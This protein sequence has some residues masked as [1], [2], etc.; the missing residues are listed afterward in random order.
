[1]TKNR[2]IGIRN[3]LPWSIKAD[4]ARFKELTLGWPCIMGRNTWASLP[5][6]P[7]PGRPN[8][9]ISSS[10]A[11]CDAPG[12]HVLPSL[13][14]AISYCKNSGYKKMFI[15]G[16]ASIYCEALSIA[17]R[18]ELTLIGRDYEGDVFFPEI[19]SSIWKIIKQEDFDG[20]SFLSYTK[21]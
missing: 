13:E 11:N 7:L 12:A 19:N 2:A 3:S 14:K 18:I 1:M 9:V 21:V 20:F 15:C 8:I 5:K 16:G 10:L 6:R 4:L 17:G